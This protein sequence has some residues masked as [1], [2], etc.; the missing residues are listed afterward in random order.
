MFIMVKTDDKTVRNAVI[1]SDAIVAMN[2]EL[3]AVGNFSHT[4]IDCINGEIYR[5]KDFVTDIC[6][7]ITQ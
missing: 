4:R 7:L 6:R 2:E 5:V 3:D 1:E